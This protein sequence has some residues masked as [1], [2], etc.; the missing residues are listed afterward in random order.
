M[1][2]KDQDGLK[3][4]FAKEPNKLLEL[5]KKEYGGEPTVEELKKLIN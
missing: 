3:L 5:F 4:M 2:E 1:L